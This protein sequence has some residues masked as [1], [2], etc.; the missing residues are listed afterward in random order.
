MRTSHAHPLRIADILISP[1]R[2][3]IGI[4]FAPGKKQRAAMSGA[5]DRDL[6]TDLDIIAAWNAA[7]VVTFELAD[8]RSC[9][10]V[11][12]F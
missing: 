2:G 3:K 12:G 11:S 8:V 7:A 4:T 9:I 5:W 1:D 10:N 6:G